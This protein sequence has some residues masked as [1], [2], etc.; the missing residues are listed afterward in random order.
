MPNPSMIQ[1][2][3]LFNLKFFFGGGDYFLSYFSLNSCGVSFSMHSV[4]FCFV[5]GVFLYFFFGFFFKLV[6]SGFFLFGIVEFWGDCLM[7]ILCMTKNAS[8]Y[9]QETVQTQTEFHV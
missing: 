8:K 3:I 6:I 2:C 9:F 5:L 4:D 1:T 7:G